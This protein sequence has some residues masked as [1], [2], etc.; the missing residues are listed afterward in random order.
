MTT[1]TPRPTRFVRPPPP[2]LDSDCALFLDI[3]GTIADLAQSPDA[4]GA[5]SSSAQNRGSPSKRG[6]HAQTIDASASTSAPMRPLPISARSSVRIAA[7]PA[8]GGGSSCGAVIARPGR[9]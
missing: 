4:V 6:K 7:P 8:P 3:D 2:P 9:R 5:V 1:P